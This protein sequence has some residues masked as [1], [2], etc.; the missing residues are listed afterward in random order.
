MIIIFPIN[1]KT[2]KNLLFYTI[3][4]IFLSHNISAQFGNI[5]GKVKL[6]QNYAEYVTIYIS[7][8]SSLGASTD[9]LG[10]YEI[11]NIPFGTYEVFASYIGYQ[12]QYKKV[13]LNKENQVLDLDFD[14]L[15]I[16]NSLNEIV[17]TGTKTFKNQNDSPI[18]VNVLNSKILNNVQ[19]CNLSEGLIFQAGLRVETNCQTCNYTQLRMNGLAGGYSQILINGRPIFSPLTGLYGLELSLIHI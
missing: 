8:N 7:N 15:Q 12:N 6:D 3:T 5:Q 18:M 17:I 9:S 4:F 2:I 1:S 16:S 13:V 19:A 14:L 11:K 10:F